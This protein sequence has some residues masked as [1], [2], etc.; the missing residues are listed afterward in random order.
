[1]R[2]IWE[3][4]GI[5]R[6]FFVLVATASFA[7]EFLRSEFSCPTPS[8]TSVRHQVV[9]GVVWTTCGSIGHRYCHHKRVRRMCE[10]EHSG[11]G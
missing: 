1:M 8:P 10:R 3:N 2:C 6:F 5:C 11:R 7:M 9:R 4:P